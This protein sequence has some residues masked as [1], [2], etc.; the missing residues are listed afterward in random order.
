MDTLMSL[1][2]KLDAF[3]ADFEAGKPTYNV[4]YAMIETMHRA[5][6]CKKSPGAHPW[7]IPLFVCDYYFSFTAAP[8]LLRS[9]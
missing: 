3:K 5:T 7:S 4:P 1:Q 8:F 2:A 6:D 9:P